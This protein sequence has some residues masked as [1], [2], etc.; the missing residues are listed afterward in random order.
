MKDK[1]IVRELFITTNKMKRVLDKHHQKNDLYLGQSRILTYLYRNKEESIYQKDIET[2]FQIRGGTVTGMLETLEKL[3]LINRVESTKDK[4]RRKVML[5][6]SGEEKAL[7][8]I[9]T[10]KRF[11]E[12]IKAHLTTQEEEQFYSV[13]MKLNKLVDAE[14]I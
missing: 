11:E 5:T 1:H 4:R 9:K 7:D 12:L 6:I 2:T 8:A 10:N 14:E 3:D 13:L